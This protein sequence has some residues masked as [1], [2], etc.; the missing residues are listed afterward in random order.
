MGTPVTLKRA[1]TWVGA[2]TVLAAW[3]AS[4]AAPSFGPEPASDLQ[5]PRLSGPDL[6]VVELAAETERLQERL[7][8]VPAVRP[9]TRNPFRFV[10]QPPPATSPAR[11]AE[12]AAPATPLPPPVRLIGIAEASP[13][14]ADPERTAIVSLGGELL[15]VT[16][17]ESIGGRYRVTGIG[18]EAIEL[19]DTLDAQTLRIALP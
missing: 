3:L 1:A 8:M 10:A 4:A 14:S 16:P 6:K 9:V 12:M 5:A 2:G 15:L 7:R 17:G 11:L 13:G 18:A 19:E